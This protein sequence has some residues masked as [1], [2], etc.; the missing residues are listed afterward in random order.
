MSEICFCELEH[1]PV[2]NG[3]LSNC[4]YRSGK[5]TVQK[6]SGVYDV[7]YQP[8]C[9]FNPDCEGF[10]QS[11][12]SA[13]W[14]Q[15]APVGGTY[16]YDVIALI[17][18]QKQEFHRTFKELHEDVRKQVEISESQVRY[19]YTHQYLP[20]LACNERTYFNQLY[21]ASEK[22][23]LYLSLDGLAPEGGEPQLWV[24]RELLTG[25]TLL[26]G[27]MSMQDQRAF[28]NFLN[29]IAQSGLSVS[30]VLSDKQRGLLPAIKT[31]F[32]SARH[33]LCQ[34]HYLKNIAEP[35]ARADEEMKVQL[36]KSVRSSIGPMIRSEHVEQPGVLTVTGLFPSEPE[37]KLTV[38]NSES[39]SS[40]NQPELN[41]Q[42]S[43]ESSKDEKNR[44]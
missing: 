40:K 42:T 29:P 36:R 14:L 41:L 17:G 44:K 20:L 12:R 2:C 31:V 11:L 13:E 30:A 23:G 7:V 21:E 8:K 18:W 1:C 3:L 16:G 19:L 15:I 24:V 34:S 32:P 10:N 26:S 27:W 4:N 22:T 28:E 39:A 43:D 35:I 37:P 5:K 38:V 33:A 9:C 25:L 6:L